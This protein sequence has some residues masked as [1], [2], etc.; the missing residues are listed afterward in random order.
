[1]TALL[2]AAALS[3]AVNALDAA[4]GCYDALDYNCAEERLAEAVAGDLDDAQRQR[5][6][7]Y[8]ALVALAFRD[9]ARARAAVR[10]LLA[11]NPRFEPGPGLPLRF[12]RLVDEERPPPTPPPELIARAD[13]TDIRLFGN[14]ATRWSEGLG[15]EG[16]AGVLL[17]GWL[18]LELSAGYSDHRPHLLTLDGLA[19]YT[20]TVQASWR[21][22][23]GPLRVS[24]GLGLG[25]ARAAIDGVTGNQR[26][27]GG[28]VQFPVSVV[29]PV[30]HGFGIGIRAAPTLF[31]VGDAGRAA[32]SWMLPLTAGLRYSP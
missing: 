1:M 12:V 13:V 25:A 2:L 22:P 20:F 16:A 14:D 26:Y 17:D 3:P 7:L 29:W 4:V 8:Q 31:I 32:G 18:A 23:L 10:A 30:W 24:A 9:D 11:D 19:L 27:W 21:R 28:L 6:H 15:V 5:A